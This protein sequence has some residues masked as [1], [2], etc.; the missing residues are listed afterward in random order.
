MCASCPF[1]IQSED[2]VR[3]LVVLIFVAGIGA[4]IAY[5]IAGRGAPPRITIAKPDRAV[6]QAGT[7]EVSTEAPNAQFTVTQHHARAERP[8]AAP[9]LAG[10]SDTGDRFSARPQPASGL[11]STGQAE[12]A[13]ASV[14][15]GAHRRH[16]RPA[17]ILETPPA[18]ELD[19][20]RRSS[21]ARAT[22]HCRV[23]DASLCEPRRIGNG[24][25][26]GDSGRRRV[27]GARRQY[28]VTRDSPPRAQE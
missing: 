11:T 7:L 12:R 17:I 10:Q 28:R 24:R 26:P 14:G 25:V 6:G 21:P 20:E 4:G 23:V 16:R 1:V 15:R 27:G 3:A 9:V 18:D 2:M 19:D 22:A 8:F 13:G 5:V